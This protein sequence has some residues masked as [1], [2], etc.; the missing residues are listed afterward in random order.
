METLLERAEQMDLY[1][2]EYWRTLLHYKRTP[3]GTKSLIDDPKFFL[4]ADGRIDPESELKAT[5]RALFQEEG[6]ETEEVICRFIGRY[7]WLREKLG[8][9]EIGIPVTTC[10]KFQQTM[11]RIKPRA[12]TLIFPTS[13]INSPASM[14]GHTLLR[15]ETGYESK[16][17]SQAVNYS[18]TTDETNGFLFAFKGI[19]GFYEGYFSIFPYYDKVEEYNDIDQRDIWEYPLALTEEEV[20]R[21]LLH[22]WELQ[23]IY[24]YYYFF[25]ENC[26]YTLLFLL[27]A[28]RP[29]LHLTDPFEIWVMPIG[30]LRAVQKSGLI[31]RS[32]YRPS[33]ATRIK[34]LMGLMDRKS[35]NTALS[36]AK[37]KSEPGAALEADMPEEARVRILDL[38]AEHIQYR[39]SKEEIPKGEYSEIFLK[40]L[41]ARSGLGTPRAASSDIP[42]LVEPTQ[43]HKSNKVSVAY[44]V[45]DL[46]EEHLFL[47]FRYR[48][49]YHDLLDPD[50]GYIEGAQI[51]FMDTVLRYYPH[52][53]RF[54]IQSLELLN[55]LSIAPRDA[56]FKPISWKVNTGLT[57]ETTPKGKDA[58]LYS[59]NAGGGYSYRNPLAGPV[60]FMVESDI[61]LGDKLEDHYSLGIGCS[62]GILRNIGRIWKLHLYGR[63]VYCG[64]AEPYLKVEFG[65]AQRF[66]LSANAAVNVESLGRKI[67]DDLETEFKLSGSLYF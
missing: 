31:E 22:L 5:I 58:L 48:P 8:A 53:V 23:S 24:S 47:E 25:D 57:R 39:Y 54:Q 60:S 35:Q 36:I 20:L 27:D 13:F 11:D 43:G 63:P 12:A 33:K 9:D 66:R 49:T 19:F 46:D 28:A 29:S 10:R 32:E 51:E 59:L 64:F 40:T 37:G 62:L 15:I 16:L 41:R 26:S 45:T 18:A 3:F 61:R 1:E 52:P 65:C 42:V 7:V 56:F 67:Q 17:L 34:V 21:M 50:E 55:I 30:T 4:A 38:A 14:F 2:D 6:N 44:G